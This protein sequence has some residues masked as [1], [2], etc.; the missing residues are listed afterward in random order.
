MNKSKSNKNKY[1]YILTSIAIAGILS[2][3]SGE[4]VYATEESL[5]NQ[6]VVEEISQRKIIEDP[7]LDL[8]PTVSGLKNAD[9]TA[10]QTDVS[11]F[12]FDSWTGTITDYDTAGGL[13]VV[14][15]KS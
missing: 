4:I 15:P 10:T 3:A 11:F 6:T 8:A 7:V 5:V 13:D 9:S 1:K 14:I 2:N 12:N